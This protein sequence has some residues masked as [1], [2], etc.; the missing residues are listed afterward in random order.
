MY[1]INFAIDISAF[2]H[3]QNG[4]IMKVRRNKCFHDS[5]SPIYFFK[6]WR[7]RQFH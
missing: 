4:E 7:Q 2:K 5:S 3:Q 6:K 1:S